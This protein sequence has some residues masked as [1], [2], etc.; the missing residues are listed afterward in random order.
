VTIRSATPEDVDL[1]MSLVERLDSELVQNPYDDDPAEV[2]RAKV[3]RMV[4]HGVALLA[5]DDG[6]PVG[7]ALARYG[8][9]G[10]TTAYVSDLW[11]DGGAR[12]QGLGRELLRRV[13]SAAAERGV[14]HVLLDV[15]AKNRAAIAFYERLGFAEIAKI[16]RISLNGLLREQEPKAESVGALHVQTD[17]VQAVERVVAEYLPR[18]LRGASGQVAGGRTWTVVRIDPF[19]VEAL[20]K[21]GTELSYRFGVTVA[22]TLEEG[23]V[24]R[25]IIHDHGR[26]VDEYLS[27]PEHYGTLPPGDALALRANPTV[28][29][30]LTGAEAARVRSTA[31]TANRP[32]ELPPA[33]ELYAQ[34]AELL[35]LEA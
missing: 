1:L 27:V 12:R 30:R 11:V 32:D 35:G 18:T 28:V 14:T 10:P 24:V 25:W 5:E 17:D 34:L 23:T 15:D 19:D 2:E 29:A 7:Y 33:E 9:H 21:L 26:M 31:R 13:A 6:R 16:Y 8:D 20:R 22:L 4:S 3:E